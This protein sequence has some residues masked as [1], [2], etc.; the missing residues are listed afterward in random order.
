M[1]IIANQL[2]HTRHTS[3]TTPNTSE[4]PLLSVTNE[5]LIEHF[6]VNQLCPCSWKIQRIVSNGC[7]FLYFFLHAQFIKWM[8]RLIQLCK[9][10]NHASL[11][12]STDHDRLIDCHSSVSFAAAAINTAKESRYPFFLL[13]FLSKSLGKLPYWC[14]AVWKMLL[15]Q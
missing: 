5:Q 12:Q 10:K 11:L 4:Y 14:N 3:L 2:G 13:F 7:I 15:K 6:A 1:I 8:T 9:G